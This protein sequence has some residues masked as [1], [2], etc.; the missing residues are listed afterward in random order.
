MAN[1][2][3]FLRSASTSQLNNGCKTKK[4]N[5]VTFSGA[6]YLPNCDH[7]PLNHSA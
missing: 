3:I 5:L 2:S 4:N 7:R 1:Q 6:N